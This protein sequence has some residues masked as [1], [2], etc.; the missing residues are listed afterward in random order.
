MV[1]V[2]DGSDM[3]GSLRNPAAFNNV[4]GF[5][6]SFGRVPAGPSPEVFLRQLSTDGPM[7]RTVGD[8]AML[9]LTFPEL[10]E[11]QGAVRQ[12]LASMNASEEA[13]KTWGQLVA[14]EIVQPEED[15][16]FE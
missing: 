2:A 11:V 10:K 5:R 14:Q 4:F 9:L 1:P 8:L 16:E 6:P 7:A 3:M 13:L 15:G 12:A